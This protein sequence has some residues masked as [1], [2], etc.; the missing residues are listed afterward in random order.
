M[1]KVTVSERQ[2]DNNRNPQT[3]LGDLLASDKFRTDMQRLVAY[4]IRTEMEGGYAAYDNGRA[5]LDLPST[6]K[7]AQRAQRLSDAEGRK[8]GYTSFNAAKLMY[9]SK[10]VVADDETEWH[11]HRRDVHVL[12]HSHP[13]LR[14]DGR[15]GLKYALAPSV[16]DL[17]TWENSML[18]LPHLTEGVLAA[19]RTE[20]RLLLWHKHPQAPGDARYAQLENGQPRDMVL[21]TMCDSGIR[22]AELDMRAEP[23]DYVAQAREAASALF[24]AG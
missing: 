2:T 15:N 5:R 23:D 16:S 3:F 1:T 4:T 10:R 21:Q 12:I 20:A 18:L 8:L 14:E 13:V 22:L 11:V 24:A 6:A 7:V 9:R 17:E 19:T